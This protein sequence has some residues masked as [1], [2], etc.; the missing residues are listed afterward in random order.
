MKFRLCLIFLCAL[1]CAC[2]PAVPEQQHAWQMA[3]GERVKKG[4]PLVFPGD[5]GAHPKQGIEWWYITANLHTESGE[6]FGIQ[7]TLFRAQ[8]NAQIHSQWWDNNVYFAHFAIQHQ[9]QHR[10]Y[11][12]FAR[13]K[14]AQVISFP[15]SASIDDWHLSSVGRD[16]LPL[17]LSA[18][19][20]QDSID[21]TLQ[22]SPLV[23]HGEQGYSQKTQSGHASYYF[24]YPFLEV[25][26]HVTFAGRRYQV[27]GNAWY[28]REWSASLIDK[29]QLGWDW[30]SLVNEQERKQ[31]LML[32]CVRS[33]TQEY[34]Y[35]SATEIE[36]NG[37]TKV[38]DKEQIA[39]SVLD[40]VLLDGRRYPSKWQVDIK[41]RETP[42]VIEALTKDSRNDLTFAYWEGR[43]VASGGFKG[44]GYA[45]L[46]GY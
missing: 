46:T 8:L 35:C 16:F 39:L 7:W 15:F 5:H 28:D 41:G 10:A 22:N 19:Q 31:G 4:T 24:S 29:S 45:E 25:S 3:Q 11:E 23:L 12:R 30:F 32:F 38:I 44:K 36:E 20:A 42:I 26:G 43:V 40:H 1:L 27:R 14:Q 34:E 17:K 13:A 33:K 37:Q 9:Q 21:L 6:T 2:K 18:N